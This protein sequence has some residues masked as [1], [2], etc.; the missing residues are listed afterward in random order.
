VAAPK[1]PPRCMRSEIS[2]RATNR[3]EGPVDVTS[4]KEDGAPRVWRGV[5]NYFRGWPADTEA[6]WQSAACPKTSSYVANFRFLTTAPCSP[7]PRLQQALRSFPAG[8]STSW[9]QSRGFRHRQFRLEAVQPAQSSAAFFAASHD[10]SAR[11][12]FRFRG[13]QIQLL[14]STQ[15]E[16]DKGQDCATY[17]ARDPPAAFGR[18]CEA[19]NLESGPA[20]AVRYVRT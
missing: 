11:T 6:I 12:S 10:L 14:G 19:G 9:K 20:V 3:K 4:G 17:L 1:R 8:R 18:K 7:G 5:R 15:S 13:T 2:G 16:R